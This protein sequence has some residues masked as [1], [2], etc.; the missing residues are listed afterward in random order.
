MEKE[1]MSVSAVVISK[2]AKNTIRRCLDGIK[3]N[4][5]LRGEFIL[6]L[7]FS[8]RGKPS[9]KGGEKIIIPLRYS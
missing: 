5:F 3:P 7:V 1:Q 4:I 6:G 2:D 8:I 9:S